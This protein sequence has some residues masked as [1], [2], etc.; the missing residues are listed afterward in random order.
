LKGYEVANIPRVRVEAREL[1]PNASNEEKERSFRTLHSIFKRQ[2]NKSGILSEWKRHQ[3]YESPSEKR[4]RK[5]KEAIINNHKEKL[6]DRFG[7]K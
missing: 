5:R 2:V 6:R 3:F 1:R 4:R 7:K